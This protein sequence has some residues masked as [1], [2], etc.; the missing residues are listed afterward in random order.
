MKVQFNNKTYLVDWQ[1]ERNNEYLYRGKKYTRDFT[2][3]HIR[4]ISN[5]NNGAE[6]I[7]TAQRLPTDIF[8][9]FVGRENSLGYALHSARF[10]SLTKLIFWQTYFQSCNTHKK[11]KELSRI[12]TQITDKIA[13]LLEHEGVRA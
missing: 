10:D 6:W 3:C 7:G 9:K 13:D 2:I 11:G 5:T 4:D 1:Y 12:K 8:D